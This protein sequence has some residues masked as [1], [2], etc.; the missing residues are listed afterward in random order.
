MRNEYN[1]SVS[2]GTHILRCQRCGKKY[3]DSLIRECP[4]EPG[5][6]YCMYCCGSCSEAYRDGSGWGCRAADAAR[7]KKKRGAA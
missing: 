4:K 1:L 5:R 7:S 3:Y 2:Q 6:K